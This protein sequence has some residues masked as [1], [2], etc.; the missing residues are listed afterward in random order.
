MLIDVHAHALSEAFT[1]QM[2]N[3]AGLGLPLQ[4]AG[5]RK[6]HLSGYGPLDSLIYDLEGR[7]ES[8]KRRNVTLQLVGPPPPMIS[9]GDKAADV[10]LARLINQ[11]TAWVVE[12]GENRIGGL[13]VPPVGDPARAADEIRRA[14]EMH[15]FV[16]VALGTNA[17]TR[18]LDDPAFEAMFS[19]IEALDLFIFMHSTTSA[20]SSTQTEYMLRT[21]VGWPTETTVAVS[22][23]IFGGVLER[24]PNLKLVLSHGGGT[25]PNL[26]GR[27]DLAWSAPKYEA[28]PACRAQI[29]M[30]PSSYLRNLHF[31]TVVASA[32]VLGFVIETFGP[33]RVLF[34]TDFPYEIGDAEGA[35]AM[36]AIERLTELD[37]QAILSE[38]AL[39]L[40]GKYGS[41]LSL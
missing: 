14:V 23:L 40:L 13:V 7:L 26:I 37:Q 36:P 8:L 27:I 41:R 35:L 31:D 30:P 32:D 10:E 21:L 25:L 34:G 24:H 1:L 15:G 18:T 16:G 20:L 33:Q 39:R 12:N 28:N 4:V 22:R 29:S 3:T 6:Y 11:S 38:N 5:P 2:A 9:N 17:G 19:A